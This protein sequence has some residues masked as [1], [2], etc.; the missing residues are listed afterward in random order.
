MNWYKEHKTEW[1]LIIDTV[2][3]PI[4]KKSHYGEK[5]T[6]QSLFLYEI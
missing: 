3:A 1:K 2:S 5:D 6:I 4:K